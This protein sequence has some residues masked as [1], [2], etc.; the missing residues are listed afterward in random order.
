MITYLRPYEDDVRQ[1]D[2]LLVA[3]QV[4]VE[5]YAFI[6]KGDWRQELKTC[7]V[8]PCLIFLL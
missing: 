5:V 4:D 3:I 7:E 6:K 2:H 1:V 8:L